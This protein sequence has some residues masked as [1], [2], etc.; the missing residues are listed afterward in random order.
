MP[1][2]RL[3]GD[4]SS[5]A[6]VCSG[7]VSEPFGAVFNAGSFLSELCRS[8][9]L[10]GQDRI[11]EQKQFA[12]QTSVT[13]DS[14]IAIKTLKDSGLLLRRYGEARM[15]TECNCQLDRIFVAIASSSRGD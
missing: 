14:D 9:F 2:L 1:C 5:W 11:S 7:T 3:R 6:G 10:E 15:T 4:C 8:Y 13:I 12:S